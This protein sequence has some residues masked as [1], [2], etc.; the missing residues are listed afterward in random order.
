[1]RKVFADDVA[2]GGTEDIADK[3]DI[4]WSSLHGPGDRGFA[5][6]DR[7]KCGQRQSGDGMGVVAF[8][9]GTE[10]TF[11]TERAGVGRA[12]K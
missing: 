2:A 7:D 9:H 10:W 4:H 6:N 12:G 5:R 11:S 1:V 8:L 3:E